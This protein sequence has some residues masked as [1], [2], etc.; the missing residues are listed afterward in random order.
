MTPRP[1]RCHLFVRQQG[2]YGFRGDPRDG[3][4][5]EW[6]REVLWHRENWVLCSDDRRR[7]RRMREGHWVGTPGWR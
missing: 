2:G 3:F 7:I 4:D 5:H 1:A 6:L